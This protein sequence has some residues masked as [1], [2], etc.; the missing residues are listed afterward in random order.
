MKKSYFKRIFAF[1]LAVL[2]SLTNLTGTSMTVYATGES[3]DST[4]TTNGSWTDYV[5]EA[6][7]SGEGTETSPY[8]IKTADQLALLAKN[9]VTYKSSYFKVEATEIDLSAHEWVP[10]SEFSGTFDGNG[11]SIE[12]LKIGTAESPYSTKGKV[13]LFGYLNDGTVK[14]LSVEVAI[15]TN[16]DTS[17]DAGSLPHTV[18]AIAGEC[19]SAVVDGCTVTGSIICSGS[20]YQQLRVGGVAGT[21]I[22]GTIISNCI[23]QAT[24]QADGNGVNTM[25][26][27]LVAYMYDG[28]ETKPLP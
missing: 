10:I 21:A 9:A 26:G 12:G 22:K 2:L 25:A 23:N 11:V 20:G 19:K 24:L 3:G 1:L 28:S 27:G 18:G 7:D 5:A 17:Q 13:G 8:I 6:F 4:Q 14:D 15:Y 16:G